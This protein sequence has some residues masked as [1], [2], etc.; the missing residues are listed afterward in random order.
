MKPNKIAARGTIRGGR[1]HIDNSA[2]MHHDCAAAF[3]ENA[4]LVITVERHVSKPKNP[5]RAYY[6]GV[7]VSAI[8]AEFIR[9]GND[10]SVEDTHTFLKSKFLPKTELLYTKLGVIDM[11]SGE[12]VGENPTGKTGTITI[13]K[14]IA[15]N[16]DTDSP[17]FQRYVARCKE[18]GSEF[19]GVEWKERETL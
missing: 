18:F 7:V 10:V 14:S 5:A 8:R 13:P 19:F 4:D 3:G 1:L 11:Q 12:V 2:A 17:E 16:G 6:F 15:K 9:L